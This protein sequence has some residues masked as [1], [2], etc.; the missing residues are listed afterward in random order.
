MFS[1][2]IFIHLWIFRVFRVCISYTPSKIY[3]P[4]DAKSRVTGE[5]PDAQKG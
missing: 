2:L 1:T 5:D 4:P 3:W